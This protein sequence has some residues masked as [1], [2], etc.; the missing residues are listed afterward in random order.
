MPV[1]A[2]CICTLWGF[3]LEGDFRGELWRPE[4]GSRVS[5]NSF[6]EDMYKWEEAGSIGCLYTLVFIPTRERHDL[7]LVMQASPGD[8]DALGPPHGL[9]LCVTALPPRLLFTLE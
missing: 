7:C 4:T 9:D 2:V 8:T 5:E 1:G 6:Q 3:G